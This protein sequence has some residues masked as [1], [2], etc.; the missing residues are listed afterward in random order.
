MR[1]SVRQGG[2][3]TEVTVS[4]TF[5]GKPHFFLSTQIV[6]VSQRSKGQEQCHN[7]CGGHRPSDSDGHTQGRGL[8]L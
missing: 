8:P 7:G 1:V 5:I 2:T 3:A 6:R 4:A